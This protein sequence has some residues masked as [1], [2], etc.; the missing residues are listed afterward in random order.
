MCVAVHDCPHNLICVLMERIC[1]AG[2]ACGGGGNE[3]GGGKIR[4]G[5]CV[6]LIGTACAGVLVVR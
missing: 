1:G 4:E 3:G 6:F 5:E 2:V